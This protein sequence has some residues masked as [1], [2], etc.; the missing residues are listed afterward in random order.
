MLDNNT[1]TKAI[2]AVATTTVGGTALYNDLYTPPA[3]TFT[4]DGNNAPQVREV[5][6]QL[7][8]LPLATSSEPTGFIPSP[9]HT[10]AEPK[11]YTSQGYA[12]FKKT[13]I[14]QMDDYPKSPEEAAARE[15]KETLNKL[16]INNF[17]WLKPRS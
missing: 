14:P 9:V 12:D 2:L 1:L 17:G 5:E 3:A 7:K 4:I 11:K 13:G 10:P 16:N 8:D 15:R 6:E